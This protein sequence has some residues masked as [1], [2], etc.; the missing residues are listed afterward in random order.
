M[1]W[2]TRLFN[3]LRFGRP[4]HILP[5]AQLYTQGGAW[6]RNITVRNLPHV[7]AGMTEF[8]RVSWQHTGWWTPKPR[9]GDIL[10]VNMGPRRERRVLAIFT[11]VA[12]P[13]SRMTAAGPGDMFFAKSIPLLY[14]DP[15]TSP[16][17]WLAKHRGHNIELV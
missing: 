11:T 1:T 16:E 4:A 12:P 3:R 10:L 14:L 8:A 15:Y 2:L 5:D 13:I 6:G 17:Y 9:V 7:P